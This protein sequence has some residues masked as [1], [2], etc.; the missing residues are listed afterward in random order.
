MAVVYRRE[1]DDPSEAWNELIRKIN[2]AGEDCPDFEPLDT[3]DANHKLSKSDI[4]GA[5]DALMEICDENEFD[6]PPRLWKTE[7]IQALIDAI[8]EGA[9]CCE[10]EDQE[11][12]EG[13]GLVGHYPVD[14]Q[15]PEWAVKDWAV[16]IHDMI[17]EK[18]FKRWELYTQQDMEL[19]AEGVV[20]K[21]EIDPGDPS[22][23][24]PV[25][26]TYEYRVKVYENGVDDSEP[27]KFPYTVE[28]EP[29]F[30]E[31]GHIGNDGTIYDADHAEVDSFRH[32]FNESS[33]FAPH[34]GKL[35]F[36]VDNLSAPWC[37]KWGESSGPQ[38]NLN[39]V[40]RLICDEEETPP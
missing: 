23:D 6:D 22:A 32:F 16:S 24:P 17:V 20:D 21:I 11:N 10:D 25:P 3:V 13:S 7:T 34:E 1:G 28:F 40:L 30:G 35:T 36:F 18:P 31:A 5:Q 38:P 12:I 2:E 26:P 19:V 9:C 27:P 33:P 29:F 37:F 39:F 14:S 4:Q 15:D 8:E